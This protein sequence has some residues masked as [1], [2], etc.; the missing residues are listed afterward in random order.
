M[1]FLK[2]KI[3]VR[4]HRKIELLMMK[5]KMGKLKKIKEMKIFL[6]RS[7]RNMEE[8]MMKIWKI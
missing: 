8:K 5:K 4:L 3:L 1:I 6:I 2:Q 7:E